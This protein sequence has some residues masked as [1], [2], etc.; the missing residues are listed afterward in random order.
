MALIF[1]ALNDSIYQENTDN[2][3]DFL[4]PEG[5]SV[6]TENCEIHL[7]QDGTVDIK[8]ALSVSNRDL[9]G[10]V[11]ATAGK[12]IE[13]F[14]GVPTVN[15]LHTNCWGIFNVDGELGLWVNMGQNPFLLLSLATVPIV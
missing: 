14:E 3:I 12:Q 9:K 10:A 15:D 7:K 8:K 11:L 4:G 13:T 5:I 1:D 6:K 2:R